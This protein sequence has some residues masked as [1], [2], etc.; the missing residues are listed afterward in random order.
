[1]MFLSFLAILSNLATVSS[2]F[3]EDFCD[4]AV[5]LE[6]FDVEANVCWIQMIGRRALKELKIDV[7]QVGFY[8]EDV[9]LLDPTR[10]KSTNLM[11]NYRNIT[12][13]FEFNNFQ[14]IEHEKSAVML[15]YQDK[16][17][18]FLFVYRHDGQVRQELHV[19]KK[20]FDTFGVYELTLARYSPFLQQIFV[21]FLDKNR[22]ISILERYRLITTARGFLVKKLK[23]QYLGRHV[24]D[25]AVDRLANDLVGLVRQPIGQMILRGQLVNDTVLMEKIAETGVNS[26]LVAVKEEH[27]LMVVDH[28][29]HGEEVVMYNMAN[30]TS[31]SCLYRIGRGLEP[32][33]KRFSI[34]C[35]DRNTTLAI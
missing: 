27:L 3:H 21:V 13:D 12:R 28:P 14:W 25:L 7:L 8:M 33:F 9:D 15:K 23:R 16:Y 35:E 20:A 4:P 19:A 34:V 6:E 26:R 17:L 22:K 1:M 30:M 10:S 18:K 29:R 32:I 11:V 2:I 31:S 5:F 24:T